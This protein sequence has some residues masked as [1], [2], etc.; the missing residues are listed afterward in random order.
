MAQQ[1]RRHRTAALE[2]F[3]LSAV[4]ARLGP[5]GAIVYHYWLSHTVLV[6]VT[7]D[8]RD[9]VAEMVDLGDRWDDLA[10]MVAVLPPLEGKAKRLN[11]RDPAARSRCDR[12]TGPAPG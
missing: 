10:E 1:A 8:N 6:I 9:T 7:I 11:K 5:S 3:S 12:F 4:Q 2:P